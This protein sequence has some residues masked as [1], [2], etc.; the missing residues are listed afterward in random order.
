MHECID[1]KFT[2]IYLL[3]SITTHLISFEK[4]FILLGNDD[5]EERWKISENFN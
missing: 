2:T 4:S 1:L 5:E 3:P